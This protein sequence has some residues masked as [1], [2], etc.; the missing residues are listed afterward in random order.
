M[1]INS[2]DYN[3]DNDLDIFDIDYQNVHD[4]FQLQDGNYAFRCL[5]L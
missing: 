3:I 2:N 1:N 5:L 4:I